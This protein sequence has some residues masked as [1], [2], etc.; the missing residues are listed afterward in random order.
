VGVSRR[1]QLLDEAKLL[2]FQRGD[3]R[4]YVPCWARLRLWVRPEG[5]DGA[6]AGPLRD[7]LYGGLW[8]RVLLRYVEGAQPEGD[9][10]LE[11]S[12]HAGQLPILE[13]DN[14]EK[15]RVM[16]VMAIGGPG[17]GKTRTLSIW[18]LLQGLD[19]PEFVVGM[20]GATSDRV[21]VLWDDFLAVAEP[22]GL[23]GER[24]E[25][26][27]GGPVVTLANGAR[28]EFVA[29]KEP[30][31]QMGSP[32]QGRSW[33]R[34]VVD[35]TQNVND[36]A[37]ADIDERGRRA[38]TDYR[39]MESATNFGLGH[40][41]ARKERYKDSPYH[42]IVRLNPL[43]NVFVERAY[44]ERFRAAY[45][46]HEWR[47]RIMAEDVAPE[48]LV[49]SSFV[50]AHNVLPAPRLQ[51]L[52]IT[53]QITAEKFG[54]DTG[55]SWVAGTDFGTLCTVTCWLKAF[56]NP[57][58]GGVD[59]WVMH[60][61]TSRSDS[62][63]GQHARR[64]MTWAHPGDFIVVAD[65]GINTKDVD[66][67]DY[68]LMRREG[69]TVRP[70]DRRAIRVKHRVSMLNALLCDASNKRRLFVDCDAHRLPAAKKLVESF[71]TQV[72]DDFGNPENV[73]KNYSD[74]TH[75][76]AALSY[77]LFPFEKLKGAGSTFEVITGGVD[78]EDPVIR[79]AREIE[80][81]RYL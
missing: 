8:D 15:P 40:F 19:H 55:W 3:T 72:Y 33:H 29:A 66:K 38:G 12:C 76:P 11:I 16:R 41:A 21:K 61:T 79:K 27:R 22:L 81:R 77:G 26:N 28:Y 56:R 53:R 57:K 63:A 70:A 45:S 52:D 80:R 59:W 39:V 36:R 58:D 6:V 71:L 73:R 25:N 31:R 46:E 43:E 51:G 62:N 23:I 34:A 65:P 17:S 67:S 44:W 18:A 64:L 47:T 1:K 49:Y 60:E 32:I 50:H 37:Q 4:R 75:W 54:S 78:A 35:E 30:S 48:Q 5:E 13:Y 74:P 7:H 42:D 69:L 10:M 20:V 2:L 68:E 9:Q 14:P 24:R